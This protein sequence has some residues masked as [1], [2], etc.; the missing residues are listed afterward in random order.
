MTVLPNSKR[1]PSTK[2]A[3]ETTVAGQITNSD[4]SK[5]RR[6]LESLVMWCNENNLFLNVGKTKEL[7]I[8]FRKKGGEHVPIYINGTEIERVKSIQFLR[9][10]ITDNLSWTSHADATVKE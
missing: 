5:Y 3:D 9:V 7:I 6:Q 1:T 2:F 10:T 8:D 4:E